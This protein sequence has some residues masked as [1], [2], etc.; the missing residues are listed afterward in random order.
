MI[1][2]SLELLGFRSYHSA[3]CSF[4]PGINIIAGINAQGK[5]NLLEGVYYLSGA[6]SFRTRTDRELIRLEEDEA[7]IRGAAVSGGR[8]PF[9]LFGRM[10][11]DPLKCRMI[12]PYLSDGF[13]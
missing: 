4:D 11:E 7:A 9:F 3:A 1:L 5:T 2:N 10:R 13:C 12:L 6:R 8:E